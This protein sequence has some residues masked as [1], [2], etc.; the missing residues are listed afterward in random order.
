MDMLVVFILA[1]SAVQLMC[2]LLAIPFEL[3]TH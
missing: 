2:N 3:Q 1:I